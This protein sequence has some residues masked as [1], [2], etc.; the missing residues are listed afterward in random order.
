[1][2]VVGR[3]GGGPVLVWW[4]LGVRRGWVFF[5]VRFVLW[6]G[7]SVLVFTVEVV[8]SWGWWWWGGFG[9]CLVR[10]GGCCNLGGGGGE[11]WLL[12]VMV[13]C[14]AELVFGCLG[15]LSGH[16]RKGEVRSH[17]VLTDAAFA[18]L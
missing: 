5:P 1:M 15:F 10:S 11:W 2:V 7:F 6:F 4:W 3:F 17:F 14:S 8:V 16:A 13:R 9:G 12:V 18:Y